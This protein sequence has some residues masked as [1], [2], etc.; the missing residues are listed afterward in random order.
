MTRAIGMARSAASSNEL[1]D[2]ETK[3][4]QLTNR[5]GKKVAARG[6]PRPLRHIMLALD[7]TSDCEPA[8]SWTETLC[9]LFP[10]VRVTVASVLNPEELI[11]DYA[12]VSI[13]RVDFSTL[14]KREEEEADAAFDAAK[15]RLSPV[16][17]SVKRVFVRGFPGQE[18]VAIAAKA[19][20]DLVVVG[21]HGH[22]QLER[23]MLGSIA[24]AVKNHVRCHVLVAKTPA[25]AGPVLTA[26]DGSERSRAAARL[27]IRIGK[28]LHETTHILHVFGLQ[29]LRYAEI[30]EEEFRAVIAK[31]RL[32]K[33]SA[34]IHYALDFGNP[35]KQI[36]KYAENRKVALI[37]M[38]S[39]GMGAF[40]S[41]M[42]GGV[43][44]RVSHE[45]PVSCLFV[46][47]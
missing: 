42:L 9:R 47:T 46:K 6:R 38:G 19:K 35:A 23:V 5:S 2:V 31:H 7:P 16:A 13:V 21:S 30:G 36:L 34:K 10:H 25:R 33:A 14:K 43:S 29:F 32:P 20:P 40:G 44:N 17:K 12:D 39:R 26:V 18:L 8:L 11:A 45:S 28:E 15:A 27:A 24:D 22:G 3:I 1:T 41:A 4:G 37:I